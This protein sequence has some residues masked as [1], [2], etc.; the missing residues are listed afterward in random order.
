MSVETAVIRVETTSVFSV[1]QPRGF[2]FIT[3]VMNWPRYW[4]NFVRIEHDGVVHWSA[5]GD[6]ITVVQRFLGR[7]VTLR[8]QLDEFRPNLIR[9]RSQQHGLPE[10]AHERH[11]V[12]LANGFEYR[13]VVVYA[14][15]AG[16]RGLFDR[17]IFK[18]GVKRALGQTVH[19][20]QAQLCR[21]EEG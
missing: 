3:N 4:P 7:E 16:W 19:N 15:H 18:R 20:L 1:P 12:E 13:L 17:V 9:Y 2:A 5:P 11:F 21:L 8:L 6:R 10:L 14:P